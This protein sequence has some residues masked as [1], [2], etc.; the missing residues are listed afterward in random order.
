VRGVPGKVPAAYRD[1][2][3]D[4]DGAR[5]VGAEAGLLTGMAWHSF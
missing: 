4:E 2:G 1:L 3:V 5:G